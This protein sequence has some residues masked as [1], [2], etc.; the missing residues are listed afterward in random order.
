[1]CDGSNGHK[2][3]GAT[4]LGQPCIRLPLPEELKRYRYVTGTATS[5]SGPNARDEDAFEEINLVHYTYIHFRY[6]IHCIWMTMRAGHFVDSSISS[7][8]YCSVRNA[9]TVSKQMS[10]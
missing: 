3:V 10:I 9:Y 7:H 1:M 8:G 5:V 2:Q 6:Y 4:T